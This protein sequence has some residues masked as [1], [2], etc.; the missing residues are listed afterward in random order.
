MWSQ[1]ASAAGHWNNYFHMVKVVLIR[2]LFDSGT[3]KTSV[4]SFSFRQL[5]YF[6][7]RGS[8]MFGDNHLCNA[9]AVFNGV[10]F[11]GEID[12]NDSNFSTVIGI[13]GSGSVGHCNSFF[14]SQSASGSDLCLISNRKFYKKS[15]F[16]DSSL[17]RL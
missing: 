12:Q 6:L 1:P 16:Y 4:T 8:L 2:N 14:C 13:Y 15:G 3:A 10:G 7:P 5:C 17:Q 11:V 9:F